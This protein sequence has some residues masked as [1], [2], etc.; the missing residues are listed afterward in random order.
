MKKILGALLSKNPGK[1]IFSLAGNVIAHPDHAASIQDFSTEA[2]TFKLKTFHSDL[3]KATQIALAS[4]HIHPQILTG[5]WYNLLSLDPDF[6]L[7]LTLISHENYEEF[8][9]RFPTLSAHQ[10]ITNPLFLQGLRTL[11]LPSLILEKLLTNLR[12]IL[13]EDDILALLE[14]ES[15]ITLAASLAQ[16]CFYTAYIFNI[17]EEEKEKIASIEQRLDTQETLSAYDIARLACYKPLHTR[18]DAH[19]IL[20]TFENDAALGTLMRILISEPLQEK[21]IAATIPRLTVIEDKI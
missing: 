15:I 4:P 1:D 8:I 2:Q 11:V 3:K 10:N 19:K 20:Q 18:P 14:E 5:F 13:L 17:S 16:Y 21:D 9:E 7:L 12:R 6:Y